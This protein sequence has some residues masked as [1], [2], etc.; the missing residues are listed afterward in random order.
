MNPVT[1]VCEQHAGK[2]HAL[3]FTLYKSVI[4]VV[5]CIWVVRELLGMFQGERVSNP[6]QPYREH[7]NYKLQVQYGEHENYKL[8]VQWPNYVGN[9]WCNDPT[10]VRNWNCR[11]GWKK[12]AVRIDRYPILISRT[13]SSLAKGF[14]LD[15]KKKTYHIKQSRYKMDQ[16]WIL[17]RPESILALQKYDEALITQGFHKKKKVEDQP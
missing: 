8:Q 15:H 14:S 4:I 1:K 16:I 6:I 9:C 13:K 17:I 7:E 12:C 10:Y 5:S 3:K 2:N 11:C